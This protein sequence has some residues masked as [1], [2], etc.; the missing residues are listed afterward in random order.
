MPICTR[1]DAYVLN[2]SELREFADIVADF[3]FERGDEL[4]FRLNQD[5]NFHKNAIITNRNANNRK[6]A[7]SSRKGFAQVGNF[8]PGQ[9]HTVLI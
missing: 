7:Y 2:I 8:T 1:P 6:I 9:D 5:L 4:S 3:S